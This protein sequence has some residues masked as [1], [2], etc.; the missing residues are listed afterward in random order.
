MR[1]GQAG[2]ARCYG[3]E[4]A[5]GEPELDDALRRFADPAL[6]DTVE[7]VGRDPLRKLGAR[8]R[9]CGPARLAVAAGEPTPAL[10]LVAAAALR[11]GAFDP[12]LRRH[13]DR[14]GP[15]GVLAGC[16]QLSSGHPFLALALAADRLIDTSAPL[17]T[18]LAALNGG[19]GMTRPL[20]T[21]YDLGATR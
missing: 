1:E 15:A 7:R 6:G 14:L 20:S 8:D 18:V 12:T 5:G 3:E 4:L 17:A 21:P 13:L 10:A 16:G 2:L 9:I 11:R 19:V